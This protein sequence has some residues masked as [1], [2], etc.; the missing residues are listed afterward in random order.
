MAFIQH[1]QKCPTCGKNH[2]SLNADVSLMEDMDPFF[3]LK[4]TKDF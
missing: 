4:M 3:S 2:L 1:N